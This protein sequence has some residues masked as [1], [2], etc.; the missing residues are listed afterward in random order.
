LRAFDNAA[1][2][3]HASCGTP[4]HAVRFSYEHSSI[5]PSRARLADPSSDRLKTFRLAMKPLLRPIVS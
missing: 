3:G 2:H 5:Q 4:G 1:S